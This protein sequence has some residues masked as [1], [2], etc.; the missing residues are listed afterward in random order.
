[1]P[2]KTKTTEFPLTPLNCFN[3]A[4]ARCRG[5][6]LDV[7]P[8]LPHHLRFNEAAARCRGKRVRASGIRRQTGCFNE[9][10]ARCRGKRQPQHVT[11]SSTGRLQ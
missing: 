4:A 7:G 6:H 1:M 3:E 5:K 9:A 11:A 8:T 10:A 2:R